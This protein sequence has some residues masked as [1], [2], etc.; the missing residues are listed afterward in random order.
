[1]INL[2]SNP[3]AE[4]KQAVTH[5]CP[6]LHHVPLLFAR[7]PLRPLPSVCVLVSTSLLVYSNNILMMSMIMSVIVRVP[8]SVI[9][10]MIVSVIMRVA[11]IVAVIVLLFL[12]VGLSAPLACSMEHLHLR[13]MGVPMVVILAL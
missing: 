6:E 8:M 12:Q 2:S 7:L 1:M 11:V 9:V 5:L 10:P 13:A 3:T 4:P